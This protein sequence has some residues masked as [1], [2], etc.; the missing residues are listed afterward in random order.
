M[1]MAISNNS[2]ITSSA[3]TVYYDNGAIHRKVS[4][5]DQ[6]D[7]LLNGTE[8]S[9]DVIGFNHDDLSSAQAYGEGT[10]TGKAGITLQ[11]HE[12][13]ATFY[14]MNSTAST[15]GGW[16]QS[17]MRG[18]RIPYLEGLIPEN[19][20]SIVKPVNKK[21]G[22]GGTATTGIETVE[23]KCFIP[24]HIEVFGNT[25]GGVVGEGQ[26]YAYY[27][28]GNNAAK[29]KIGTTISYAWW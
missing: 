6:V 9:F 4:V 24:S 26:Q 18:T 29:Q 17:V 19:W 2:D 7:L 8:Y 1:A 16:K 3:T 15:T 20:R 11:M 13:F 21:T 12:L 14:Q 23:D 10:E 22:T 25:N 27:A 5:G 28:K